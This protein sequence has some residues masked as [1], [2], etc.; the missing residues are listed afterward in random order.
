MRKFFVEVSVFG[1][2]VVS[3]ENE[4][5]VVVLIEADVKRYIIF[6]MD[7]NTC[8]VEPEALHDAAT[9]TVE[10]EEILSKKTM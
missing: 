9:S 10:V 4:T 1:V 2:V 3:F 6:N 7:A 8:R 5:S